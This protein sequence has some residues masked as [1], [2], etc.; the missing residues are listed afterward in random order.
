MIRAEKASSAFVDLSTLLD[1][2]RLSAPS[3]GGGGW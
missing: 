2:W 3:L 1:R